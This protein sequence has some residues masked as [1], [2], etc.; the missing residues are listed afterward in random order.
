MSDDDLT[1][2]MK[3]CSRL[4]AERDEALRERDAAQN[5]FESMAEVAN[6]QGIKV[7]EMREVVEAERE[8][9]EAQESLFV[10]YRLGSGP[11]GAKA[12]D[13]VTKAKA[14][15]AALDKLDKDTA[16]GKD[17]KDDIQ[18]DKA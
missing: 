15:L 1:H 5:R 8:L 18:E 7:E 12:A 4:R 16:D 10:A 11:R 14:R 3:S 6:K 17:D 2:Y 9:I 13:R